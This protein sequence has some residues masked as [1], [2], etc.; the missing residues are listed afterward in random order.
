MYNCL[1]SALVAV[2]GLLNCQLIM[3][4]SWWR[5]PVP[6]IN[7]IL[8]MG[9]LPVFGTYAID[10]IAMLLIP[11]H[12]L[13]VMTMMITTNHSWQ[14]VLMCIIQL[15]F[16]VT[17]LQGYLIDSDRMYQNR[18]NVI[19]FAAFYILLSWAGSKTYNS[20]IKY[21]FI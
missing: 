10:D 3:K 15:T 16:D 18:F 5:L 8:I 12:I 21:Q 2:M 6:F 11:M 1:V 14:I 17:Y 19:I 13:H 9:F 4:F 7:N 20:K